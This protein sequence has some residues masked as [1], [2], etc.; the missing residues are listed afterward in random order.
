MLRHAYP[1]RYR[2]GVSILAALCAAI[3]WGP[4]SRP[5]TRSSNSC[6]TGDS[7]HTWIDGV[8]ASNGK[9]IDGW[10][11]QVDK[12]SEQ[13]KTLGDLPP[14]KQVDKHKRDVAAKLLEL[15]VKLRSARFS[16]YWCQVLRRWIHIL[17]PDDCFLS[18]A[19][20]IGLVVLGIVFKCLFEFCQDSLVG[21][22]VNYSAC[23]T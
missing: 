16:S 17:L 11:T 6:N 19:Y 10:Q 8:I 2:L 15:E 7:L 1:Y 4:T 12:L 23:A 9:D 21:S 14:S 20:L 5:F 22:V 18:L 13:E 3:L